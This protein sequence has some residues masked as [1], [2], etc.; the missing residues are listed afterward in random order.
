MIFIGIDLDQIDKMAPRRVRSAPGAIVLNRHFKA[1]TD[2]L[3]LQCI[4]HKRAWRKHVYFKDT[5]ASINSF[6]CKMLI[7]IYTLFDFGR[8]FKQL[9][10]SLSRATQ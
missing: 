7:S 8:C 2:L 10:G 4:C 5:R 3:D 6:M 1:E 9:I